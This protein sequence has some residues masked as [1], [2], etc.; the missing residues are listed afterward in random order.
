MGGS[1]TCSVGWETVVDVLCLWM[2]RCPSIVTG[3]MLE[4]VQ[5]TSSKNL[6][7]TTWRASYI[8]TVR[9]GTA[10]LSSDDKRLQVGRF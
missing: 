2:L 1:L 9:K 5:Y 6:Q 10:G 7:E 4:K 8:T 3:G